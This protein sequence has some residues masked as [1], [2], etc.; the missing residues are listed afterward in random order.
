MTIFA[1][2]LRQWPLII[3]LF[4][5]ILQFLSHG[6]SA[7]SHD[8]FA[9]LAVREWEGLSS[10]DPD[11]NAIRI[12]S[13]TSTWRE[14]EKSRTS[15]VSSRNRWE[16]REE[17]NKRDGKQQKH[18]PTFTTA[19]TCHGAGSIAHAANQSSLT[20]VQRDPELRLSPFLSLQ[21]LGNHRFFPWPTLRNTME[22]DSER[23][24]TA[25]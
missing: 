15:R 10:R 22:V 5:H 18:F 24:S 23:I 14:K 16:K 2:L 17:E 9:T 21:L 8:S 6:F 19:W 1:A 13:H 11:G 25:P 3:D 12:D 20:D 4:G 7:R